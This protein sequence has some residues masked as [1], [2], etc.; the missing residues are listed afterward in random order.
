MAARGPFRV[1]TLL[2]ER[3]TRR[4]L[5]D[6]RAHDLRPRRDATQPVTPGSSSNPFLLPGAR[7]SEGL[8]DDAANL[9]VE[10]TDTSQ[11]R[12]RTLAG[13]KPLHEIIQ[14]SD[15]LEQDNLVFG[16]FL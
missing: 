14:A 2:M 12:G 3:S 16:R 5:N 13:S 6:V 15:F 4:N 1:R 9:E 11:L 7:S 8:H 10:L